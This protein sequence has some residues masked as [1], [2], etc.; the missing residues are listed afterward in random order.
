MVRVTRDKLIDL[1]R[2]E[3][4]R[5]GQSEDVISGY[6]IGSVADGEPLIDGTADIDLVLIH[7][8]LPERARELLPLSENIHFDI[9]HHHSD[10]YSNPPELRIHP[11]LG[12]SM[13]EPIFLY[14][15]NHFFERAQAG[16]RGQFYQ[17]DYVHA[18]SAAFLKNAR[19]FKSN[20]VHSITWITNYAHAILEAFNALVNLG[21]FPVAGRRMVLKLEDRLKDLGFDEHFLAF[22]N[23][24]GGDSLSKVQLQNWLTAWEK[25]FIAAGYFSPMFDPTRKNYFL[26]AFRNLLDSDSYTAIV[27]NLITTWNQAAGILEEAGETLQVDAIWK[28]TMVKLRI[29]PEFRDERGSELEAQLDNIEEIIEHWI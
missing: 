3:A 19:R 12:P 14:D 29:S 8:Y 22:Q 1:A 18:R 26:Y 24:L 15:P 6:L 11:W 10:L 27:W 13:C 23:L 25:N 28:D 2:A 4:E 9:T 5:R 17:L 16:V 20:M 21:G 7:T